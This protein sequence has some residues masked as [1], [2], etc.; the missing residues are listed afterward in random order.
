MEQTVSDGVVGG[1]KKHTQSCGCLLTQRCN[2]VTPTPPLVPVVPAGHSYP[3]PPRFHSLPWF[4][5]VPLIPQ[6]P[7]VSLV[8]SS[9]PGPSRPSPLVPLIYRKNEV[10]FSQNS[11]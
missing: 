10:D 9:P 3:S 2:E 5:R 6:I 1:N 7:L 11:V 8:P 4:S